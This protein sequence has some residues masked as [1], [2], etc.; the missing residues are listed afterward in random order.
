MNM[1]NILK[2]FGY[3]LLSAIAGAGISACQKEAAPQTVAI[4]A[5]SPADNASADLADGNIRFAWE[6]SGSVPGGFELVISADA[7]GA[8]AKTY[9]L[10]STVFS[11]EIKAVDMDLLMKNWEMP[12]ATSS[13]VMWTVRPAV[14][15]EATAA[16]WRTLNV[17]RLET[18]TVEIYLRSPRD[19]GFF[20]LGDEDTAAEFSWE[21]NSSIAGYRI[22]FSTTEDGDAINVTD[23]DLEVTDAATL[24]LSASDLAKILKASGLTDDIA[25]L[26]WKVYSTDELTPGAS[27]SRRIRLMKAG[28]T[29]V[30]PVSNL[31]V[32]PG[33]ERFVLTADI[34]D[35]RTTKVV[36]TYGENTET[37]DIDADQETLTFEKT[38]V[39]QGEYDFSVVSHNASG[40]TSDAETFENVSVY[41]SAWMSSK[42]NRQLSISSMTSEGAEFTV[43]GIDD[44]DLQYSELIYTSGG[45]ETVMRVENDTESILL[46]AEDAD[47]AQ[48]VT[49]KSYYSP[50][51]VAE[52]LDVVSPETPQT[53]YLPEYG[54]LVA[55]DGI[56]H[57]PAADNT[58]ALPNE[59]SMWNASFPYSKMFDGITDD[60]LNMWH[61]PGTEDNVSEEHPI[62][63]TFDLGAEYYLGSYR[64]WG[65][66]A[67]T[68]SNPMFDAGEK[69][70]YFAFGSNNP[71]KFRLY[72]SAEA[73]KN[74]TDDAYWAVDGT[75]L[76]DWTLLADSEVIRPSV[77]VP[78]VPVIDGEDNEYYV[79]TAEDFAAAVAG[80]EFPVTLSGKPVRYV[81]IVITETWNPDQ[82]YR[83]SF[84]EMHFFY[85]TPQE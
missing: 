8:S 77:N 34:T 21:G 71:R 74:Q 64:V 41:G 78:T 53:V 3:T 72:G 42:Q 12:A 35:P 10:S 9:E 2:I 26:Y 20:D 5:V 49:L 39:A 65:R 85:Y 40:E 36:V 25:V 30:S 84:G 32:V 11:R 14:E 38:S 61:T 81:R 1:K 48:T 33:Y 7:E 67:G 76:N 52:V 37:V 54:V 24:S 83:I 68:E 29:G 23:V 55:L 79:P 27:E 22:E 69:L 60:Q 31:K 28:A 4:T 66:Y 18:E 59:M 75:W 16:D 51:S 58:G 19:N 62:I 73:P 82:L 80:A 13:A 45:Q 57:Y 43:T 63:A 56:G 47:M 17:R 15:G 50:A 70:S 6:A 44:A 46:T